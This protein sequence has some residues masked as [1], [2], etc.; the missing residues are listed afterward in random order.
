MPPQCLPPADQS[1]DNVGLTVPRFPS[2]TSLE[3]PAL[4]DFAA[5]AA[6]MQQEKSVSMLVASPAKFS[7][8]TSVIINHNEK[9]EAKYM[10]D[11]NHPDNPMA[12]ESRNTIE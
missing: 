1:D 8:V 4:L 5:A 11:V 6:S 7:P 3:G 9:N 2:M 10:M 12:A